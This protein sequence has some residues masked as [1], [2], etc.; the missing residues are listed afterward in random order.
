M[1]GT[2]VCG[3]RSMT[4]NQVLWTCTMILWPFRKVWS[5]SR[6]SIV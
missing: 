2:Q 1:L 5:V 3:F 4:G 6:R